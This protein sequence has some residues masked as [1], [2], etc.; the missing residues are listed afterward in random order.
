MD[1]DAFLSPD[2]LRLAW[3][4]TIRS[5]QYQTKDRI[6]LRVYS[7]NLEPNLRSLS[8]S[9]SQG[10]YIPS[11]SEKIYAP[12]RPGTLRSFPLLT[13]A[14][15]VVYQAAVNI[16]AARA[17]AQFEAIAEGSVFAHLLNAPEDPFMIRRWDG[18]DGQYHRFLARFQQ[19]WERGHR[20]LVQ[21]DIASYYD[22]IDH[23][24]LCTIIRDRW[25]DSGQL[26]DLLGTCLRT[27]TPHEEGLN[28]SRGL[29]QGYEGSDFLATLFLL[30]TDELMIRKG[31]YLRY[32]DDVRIL[33]PDRDTASRALVDLDVSLKRQALILQPSKT[34]VHL[35]ENLSKE[36]DELAGA[37]S[38][39]DQVQRRGGD[40]DDEA[41]ELFFKS[42]HSLDNDEHAEAHLI[43]ALNRIPPTRAARNVALQ[44]VQSMPW[45]S[46]SINSYLSEFKGDPEVVDALIKE[47]S[48]HKVFA[49]HLANC[50]RALA[51]ITPVDTIRDICRGWISN[52]QLRWYQRLAAVECLQADPDSYSFL[53]LSLKEEQSYIVRS[54]L[55]IAAA[56]SGTAGAQRATVIRAGLRDPHPQVVA[57]AI[58]LFTEFPDCGLQLD[59]FSP[60]LGVGRQ[61]I[62][63][64]AQTAQPATSYVA[65]ILESRFSVLIPPDLSL[66]TT[67]APVHEEASLHLRR[68]FRY[69]DTD[70]AVFVTSL[71]NFNQVLAIK[72]SEDI[73]GRKIPREE[74]RNILSSLAAKYPAI[75]TH[76]AECHDLRSRS[77]GP[78]AWATSLGN[79]SQD[80]THYQKQ[81]LTANLASAY[82]QFVDALAMH[83]GIHV[84]TT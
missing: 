20:W 78:H 74:Y 80:V 36:V 64:F 40:I 1:W 61:M 38:M 83:E 68:A 25:L 67:L 12:K 35:V 62:P 41:E 44:M 39:L 17:K 43:F 84:L 59:E 54:S 27:W 49:W 30:P 3:A 47:V 79:W 63:A 70:P 5:R 81:R 60:E 34:G 33:A 65:A 23:E 37:L 77:I 13:V 9:L 4:R 19:L 58:W 32:V 51:C 15:R 10:T 2:N 42:W 53:L 29:P 75:S 8:E 24:L 28:F 16:I 11:P 55:I 48:S 45:R 52:P 57:A 18:P 14:D 56:Y 6:G 71:D 22:S 7:A 50:I 76:F 26:T 72:L 82:Q 69:Y 66:Y 31:S 46:G 21:A 73:E